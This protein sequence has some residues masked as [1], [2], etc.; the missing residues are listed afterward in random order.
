MD[1]FVHRNIS[2][3]TAAGLRDLSTSGEIIDVRGQRVRELRNRLTVISRPRER[4]LFLP[5]RGNDVIATLAET[6]WV[7]AGRNDIEWLA[8]YLPRAKDFSDNG[9]TWR[10]AYG[11]RLRNWNGI[12]QLAET[13][14]LLLEETASRRAVISL[15]DP[16]RDFVVSK[17]IP[18]NNWL[19]WLVRDG[20]LHLT[21]G[22]RSND[23]MWGFSGVNSFEWSVLQ[24]MMAFWIGAEVGD[25]TYLAT[26][27]HLYEHHNERARKSIEAF[28]E[29]TCYDFGVTAPTFQTP[30]DDFNQVLA[31]WFALEAQFR[32]NPDIPFPIEREIE[33]P[34]LVAA[35][36]LVRVYHGAKGGWDPKRIAEEL[37]LLPATDLT[38][39]AY[40]FFGRKHREVLEA[41]PHPNIA[42]F[43]SAYTKNDGDLCSGI[44]P[45]EVLDM[46]KNLHAQKDA[47][48]GSSWKKR[49]ELT[50]ILANVARKVDRLAQHRVSGFEL[51]DESIL[52]T[53]VDLFVYLIKYRLYLLESAPAAVF[54]AA[55]PGMTQPF[56]DD[57][58]CFNVL[59][60]SY[61]KS[62]YV[63]PS[64]LLVTS[65]IEIEFEKLHTLATNGSTLVTEKLVKLSGL[66]ELAFS[67]VFTFATKNPESIRRQASTLR[68][69]CP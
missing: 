15:Y 32:Q 18:C 16:D 25:A 60:D 49:G 17:D 36:Q 7:M 66:A 13:R 55:L 57:L 12:D 1:S 4:C 65:D 24:E 54:T 58:T 11:P 64:S 56:S 20:F 38:A 22:V 28:R 26:S 68:R 69:H 51:V 10:A 47:A 8:A 48:Y 62:N 53:A 2:F 37:A 67:L 50:S 35:L 52:D 63:T 30:F 33:D 41:A 9:T 21:I 46:I 34:F 14:R 43:L 19:H 23:I 5:H 40:E 27:F 44:E 61:L 45:P 3:A 42:S 6:L 39:S 31:S 59:A 29:I